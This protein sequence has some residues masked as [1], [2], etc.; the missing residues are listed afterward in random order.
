MEESIRS[1]FVRYGREVTG[2]G[3]GVAQSVY[4]GLR[5]KGKGKDRD[6]YGAEDERGEMQGFTKRRWDRVDIPEIFC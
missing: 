2:G 6:R 1:S 5:D 3:V 4:G